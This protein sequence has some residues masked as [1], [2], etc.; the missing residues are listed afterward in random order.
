MNIEYSE[1]SQFEED[2]ESQSNSNSNND[3]FEIDLEVLSND[4]SME[5]EPENSS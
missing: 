1:N 5:I 2:N 4:S 3:D